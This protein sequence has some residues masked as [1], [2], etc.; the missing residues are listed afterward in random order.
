MDSSL[1]QLRN[2][3]LRTIVKEQFGEID[4]AVWL[5]LRPNFHWTEIKGGEQLFAESDP[6]DDFYMVV[7]GRLQAIKSTETGGQKI[8]GEIGRGESI[9]EMSLLIDEVRSATVIALRD[10]V[11]VR[12]TKPVFEKMLQVSQNMVRHLYR[13]LIFRLNQANLGTEKPPKIQTI[14]VIGLSPNL[15]VTAFCHQFRAVL[16]RRNKVIHLDSAIC[17]AQ[18]GFPET[19]SQTEW[20]NR[21]TLWLNEQEGAHDLVIYETNPL[22]VDWTRRCLRQADAVFM[23]A[24]TAHPP[25]LTTV[26]KKWL[27][28]GV[29]NFTAHQYLL[30]QHSDN[31]AQ[32][33]NTASWLKKRNIERHFHYKSKDNLDF[34]RLARFVQ[35]RA[36]GLVLAGG[37]ARGLSHLG[38]YRALVEHGIPFDMVGGTSA[39]AIIAGMIARF[40]EVEKTLKMAREIALYNPTKGDFDLF[41]MVSLLAGKK[42]RTA[43]D[44]LFEQQLIEDLWLDFFCVSSNLTN[45]EACI[46]KSGQ[47]GRAIRASASIPGVFPPVVFGNDLHVDGGVINNLPIDVMRQLGAGQIIAADLEFERDF[48]LNYAEMPNASQIFKNRIFGKNKLN[49]PSLVDILMKASVLG[50]NQ[51]ARKLAAGADLLF[52]PDL[53]KIG[54]AAWERFDE[55]VE[56]GYNYARK[57]LEN[58]NPDA[59]K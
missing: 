44:R 36:I 37:G 13:N 22:D 12:L 21:L 10:S 48:D 19:F 38:I 52:M 45:S 26:E 53:K 35:G 59:W 40:G 58:V 18:L 28:E 25:D 43:M 47:M 2:D 55:T 29:K 27:V 4:E 30:L 3:Q 33:T 5:T 8:L 11:L 9:G 57:K 1:D 41:P 54:F 56:I 6:S 24:D 42:I 51:K 50:S 49:T 34:E 17:H 20:H 31:H 46:H 7:S 23:L 15:D 16:A 14:T 32:P 39:G